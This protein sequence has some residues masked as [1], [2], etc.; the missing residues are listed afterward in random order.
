MRLTPWAGTVERWRHLEVDRRPPAGPTAGA[1]AYVMSRF[2]KLTETFVLNE[3]LAV[4]GQGLRTEIYPLLREHQPV[5]HDEARAL[6]ARAHFEPLLSIRVAIANL[7][8][9]VV[10]PGPYLQ[11][12]WEVL[13]AAWG[14][15]NF[16]V[17]ALGILP[18][19]V[20]MAQ[21]MRRTGIRHVHAHFANHPT[22]AALIVHRLTGIPFSFTAHGSD[23]HVDRRMLARKVE[24]ASFVVAV[25][26]FNRS[27][28]LEAAGA[29]HHDKV[30]VVHCGV[31]PDWFGPRR[32]PASAERFRIICVAS[33]EP[34][35]GHCHLVRACEF[36]GARG[37]DYECYLVGDGPLRG[38]IARQIDRLALGERVRLVGPRNRREVAEIVSGCD[39]AAL[40]SAPTRSG[41]R[42]GIPVA[43]MEAMSAG[44]PVVA[45]STGGIPELVDSGNNGFLVSP[46]DADALASALTRLAEEPVLRR[47]M[48]ESARRTILEGFSQ[49]ACAA[50]LVDLIRGA[51]NPPRAEVAVGSSMLSKAAGEGRP[52]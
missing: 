30:H 26:Q 29:G 10:R 48:G 45:T 4:E 41:K 20:W 49:Q 18:K 3:V 42:E 23:V 21:E 47:R 37:F 32:R 28:I 40:A 15:A 22:V 46:R 17:G 52:G 5:V 25:S 33:F 8:A 24:A 27:L 36:L 38:D 35:K 44:L 12:W 50:A 13:R 16:F 11:V 2:P 1:V 9:L 51:Q 7:R 14:S 43:L 19:S 31:V 39:V 6:A 34:V